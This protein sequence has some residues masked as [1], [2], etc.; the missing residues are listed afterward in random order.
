MPSTSQQK[1][2]LDF[3]NIPETR[4]VSRA[5]QK[6]K[7]SVIFKPLPAGIGKLKK[8]NLFSPFIKRHREESTKVIEF[9][10]DSKD[11]KGFL[12]NAASLRPVVNE[13]LFVYCFSVALYQS[14]HTTN[15]L[16]PP[17]WQTMPYDFFDQRVENQIN[18]IIESTKGAPDKQPIQVILEPTGNNRDPEFKLSYFREDIA[19][20]SHHWHWHVIYPVGS[21]PSDKKINRKGELFYYMHEQMLA[22]YDAERLCN[23]MRRV[24][25]LHDYD[26]IIP[27][28]YYPRLHSKISGT[29]YAS[30]QANTRMMDTLDNTVIELERFRERI[31]HAISVGYIE[32]PDNT[33]TPLN[34]EQGID[35]LADL[36]EA[37]NYSLNGAYYGD[38]HNTGHVML[39]TAH[40]PDKRFNSSDGVMG[41]VQ[42]ALR[43]PLFYRWH[44]HI[45]NLLQNHKRTLQPYTDKE[46]IADKIEIKEASI[47]SSQT[48]DP[49]NK[50]YTFFD[51]KQL[52][53]T[54]GLD[55]G[56][57]EQSILVTITH[58]Q[59]EEFTYNIKVNNNTGKDFTGTFR[60]FM[61]PKNDDLDIPMEINE[62]RILMIEMDK[63]QL[64][65]SPG[66]NNITRKSEDSNV[67]LH[68]EMTWEMIENQ[69]DTSGPSSQHYCACGWPHHL[70]IPKGSA[71]GTAFHC[72]IMI[73]DWKTD[74][75]KS[76][77]KPTCQ[78]AV[79]Y[80]GI[81]NDLYPD[82]KPMGFPFDRLIPSDLATFVSRSNM[83]IF[84]ISIIHRE[85]K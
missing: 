62:Q 25:S 3:F 81:I 67:T 46:L 71:Q 58:L 14:P 60:I 50:L 48:K 26:E 13:I 10:L 59:H 69:P 43:D 68:K 80:C 37:S 6:D 83:K 61:A 16:A 12:E 8:G 30:R 40:D 70:L 33:K 21:N 49:K 56:N 85:K 57:L 64:K 51:T 31:E 52:N 24:K 73:T 9:L 72:F 32:L 4:R 35:I 38:L 15:L 17:I 44:K 36:I 19:I 54:K 29:E 34:N 82:K 27:E 23:G 75:V 2:V 28:G 20:N 22:R 5:K 11:Y 77:K 7:P 76:S 65:L 39:A 47:T 42:T 79:S 84:D 74:E 18:G 63:F 45:D 1:E 53:L 41:F 55:F 78:D 66:E